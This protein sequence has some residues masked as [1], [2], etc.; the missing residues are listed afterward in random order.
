MSDKML[1]KKLSL[2]QLCIS[3]FILYSFLFIVS[4]IMK[5]FWIS[6][7]FIFLI[8]TIIAASGKQMFQT[9]T[10][11][12]TYSVYYIILH[13]YQT[14]KRIFKSFISIIQSFN[15]IRLSSI[16]IFLYLMNQGVLTSMFDGHLSMETKL[17]MDSILSPFAGDL[18][19]FFGFSIVMYAFFKLSFRILRNTD[20]M[21]IIK[22]IEAKNIDLTF[23]HHTGQLRLDVDTL[24]DTLYTSKRMDL[25][26]LVKDNYSSLKDVQKHVEKSSSIEDFLIN[27]EEQTKE[28][29]A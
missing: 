25:Y 18:F 17:Y 4:L 8:S 16:M 12:K 10:K 29:Q 28:P 13:L 20:D 3:I 22:K 27:L 26:F 7:F 19:N 9:H 14:S 23:K 1:R 5:P 11:N 15:L 6:T 2:K 21:D 24:L